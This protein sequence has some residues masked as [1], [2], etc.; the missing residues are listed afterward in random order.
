MR[1]LRLCIK[2][3]PKK[4][5]AHCRSPHGPHCPMLGLKAACTHGHKSVA[6][7][8]ACMAPSC[9]MDAGQHNG[10]LPLHSH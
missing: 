3:G 1:E 9:W 8:F 10:V 6:S 5:L 2:S 7:V 4:C